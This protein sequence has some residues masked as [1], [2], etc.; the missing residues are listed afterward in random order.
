MK[1]KKL[2]ISILTGLCVC[3]MSATLF[4]ACDNAETSQP[5]N[6]S[7]A[8][9]NSESKAEDGLTFKTLSVDGTKVYG[10]VSNATQ[11]FSFIDE[12]RVS[13][14]SKFAVSF[15]VY[16][17]Q[18]IPTKTISLNDG[19]N[20]V[21][22]IETVDG[23]LINVYTVSL[24]RTP[25]CEITFNTNGGTAVEK[26]AV[27][28]GFFA[29]EPETTR[30]G[31]TFTGWN[32]DFS[33][34]ITQHT[35]ITA[36]WTAN[37][38]TKYTVNYYLQNAE[39]DHYTLHETVVL[40]GTTDTTATAEIKEYESLAYNVD[41]ST[42]SGNIHGDG[43]LVLSVY[44]AYDG[45][46]ITTARNNTHA[47]TVTD[48]NTY[49][50]N[51]QI[52]LTATTNV[53]YTWLGWYDGETLAC[54]T[55]EFTFK[56]EKDATY[57]AKWGKI[58]TNFISVI[59]GLTEYGETLTAVEIPTMYEGYS[60]TGIGNNAFDDCINLR[61]VEIPDSV[62]NI[63]SYAFKDCSSLT[64]VEIPDSVTNIGSYVFYGCSRLTNVVIH[65]SVT[66]IGEWAFYGCSR[67]TEITLPFVGAE[68][69]K[70]ANDTFQY[71][72]GYI[73]GTSSYEGSTA[74]EQSYYGETTSSTTSSTYYIP[75]SLK[76]V[77]ITGGNILYGAFYDCS[78]LT[79]VVIG[80]GV[81]SIGNFA[82]YKCSSLTSVVV[83]NGVASIGNYAFSSCSSLTSVA[84]GDGV[85]SIGS[86]AFYN[87]GSLT[88]VVIPD[89]VTSI[90]D[91]AF[92]NCSSLTSVEIP[93]GVTS[94]GNY[95]F[96]NCSSLTNIYITD[97]AAWCNISFNGSYSNPLYY[98]HNLYLNNALVTEL[99]I[100]NSVMS[101]GNRAFYNCSS[102]TS[103]EIPDCV[104]SIGNIAF[105]GCSSLTSI[106]IPDSV[107]SIGSYAFHNCASLKYNEKNNGKYL[108]NDNNPYFYLA[109]TVSTNIT[110]FTIDENCKAI[111]S[112]AFVSC[113]RL[114]SIKIP[115]SVTSIGD[116][117][118]AFCSSLTSVVIG[119]G[120][121]S[122]GGYAFA[123]CSSLTSIEIPDNV[124]SIDAGAFEN[125]ESLTSIEIPDSVTS[126]GAG[127]FEFCSSLTSITFKD[128]S[129]WYRTTSSTD[130]E[131]KMGGTE[132][133]VTSPSDN[134]TYFK[135]TYYIYYWYK[136]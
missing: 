53:G 52:T 86:D 94:V 130:W 7:P 68:A 71:P 110:N 14:K 44:Y 123:F 119:D 1:N 88:S 49:R 50:A 75:T 93:D 81:T 8:I 47:G 134:A 10:K 31:Y 61:N 37:T 73:F 100:P 34:P 109:D 42:V 98:A 15:D 132:T 135:S 112:D 33:T 106:T 127:A 36:G 115:D 26:Q 48:S 67:L 103:V 20:T 43:S 111:G 38:D 58:F 87:C 57:T 104:T 65:D 107:T 89:S 22:I 12:V 76:K 74:S 120:V 45:Y 113:S 85:A 25:M 23:E 35:E 55:E 77:T 116:Y 117:A 121:T 51:K 66:S 78:N 126:I 18:Q 4:T 17:L 122:T 69:G 40:T 136:L 97:I 90:G 41:K 96:Y 118:F 56:V 131:N 27:E 105:S 16:G 9:E 102:L 124:T 39:D 62:T 54:P 129:T 91:D 59:T 30:V 24:Y 46:K 79:S 63:G 92:N 72:F 5:T 21:Y 95:A 2:F 70:T 32:F 13:G 101:I 108:G 60:I 128:T 82:F 11:T 3:L 64:N 84:I 6:D 114:T 83:G 133:S 19:D 125:C 28:E 29:V 99:V 80:D